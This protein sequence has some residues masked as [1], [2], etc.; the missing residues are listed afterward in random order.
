MPSLKHSRHFLDEAT[1]RASCATRSLARRPYSVAGLIFLAVG[2][3][4]FAY[5]FPELH[6]YIRMKRM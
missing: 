1:D 4:A 3:V 5:M 2:L 6:R